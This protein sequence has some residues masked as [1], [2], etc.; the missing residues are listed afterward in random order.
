MRIKIFPDIVNAFMKV[1]KKQIIFVLYMT[2][3]NPPSQNHAPS[4][5]SAWRHCIH[6][7]EIAQYFCIEKKLLQPVWWVGGLFRHRHRYRWRWRWKI[8]T[9][10]IRDMSVIKLGEIQKNT[11]F[12]KVFN[13]FGSCI[14]NVLESFVQRVYHQPLNSNLRSLTGAEPDTD[15]FYST[16]CAL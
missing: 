6:S 9:C 2:T 1:K 4:K 7:M 15:V 5:M 10:E 16:H 12:N 13:S 8:P 3:P 11:K 14:Q